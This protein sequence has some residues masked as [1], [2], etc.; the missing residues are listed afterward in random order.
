[1]YGDFFSPFSDQGSLL[2]SLYREW[3]GGEEVGKQRGSW[4]NSTSVSALKDGT[5]TGSQEIRV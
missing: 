5:H 2:R 1:M 4:T 3:V